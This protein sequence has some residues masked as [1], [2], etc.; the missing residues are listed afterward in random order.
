MFTQVSSGAVPG[1]TPVG[2]ARLPEGHAGLL[3]GVG[4][5]PDVLFVMIRDPSPDHQR[6]AEKYLKLLLACKIN[7]GGQCEVLV[8]PEAPGETGMQRA[9]IATEQLHTGKLPV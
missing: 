9:S 3:E 1:H 5:Y 2:S 7:A 6:A 4:V 8:W